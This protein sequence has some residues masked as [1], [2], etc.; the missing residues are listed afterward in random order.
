VVQG[1]VGN[2]AP[3]HVDQLEALVEWLRLVQ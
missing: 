3:D 1:Y 2:T